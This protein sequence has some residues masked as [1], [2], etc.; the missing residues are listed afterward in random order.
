[1]LGIGQVMLGFRVC[2]PNVW[3]GD[4][5]RNVDFETASCKAHWH[6]VI[7][8]YGVFQILASPFSSLALIGLGGIW[9]KLRSKLEELRARRIPHLVPVVD[10]YKDGHC[11]ER[12]RY[13]NERNEIA[14]G[15]ALLLSKLDLTP[16]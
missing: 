14:M 12:N 8:I 13:M 4:S 11:V 5:Y 7:Q 15:T 1:M 16:S 2:S 10:T 6:D 3:P 9:V